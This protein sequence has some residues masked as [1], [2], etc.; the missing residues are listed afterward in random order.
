MSVKRIASRY[1]K[2][3]MDLAIENNKLEEV[4]KDVRGFA[5]AA[6]NRDFYLLIKSPIISKPKKTDVIN[7]VFGK[8]FNQLTLAFLDILVRKGRESYLPEIAAEFFDL[9]RIKQH[10]SAVK[11]TSASPLS[12]A[13]INE[14]ISK[15]QSN[16]TVKT[17][18]EL[19]LK[20]NPE[21]IGGF[22]VET[23]GQVID[24]SVLHKLKQL[25]HNFKDNLYISQIIAR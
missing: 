2:A 10:I 7:A 18:V 23:D 6:K 9:Y 11:I 3:L 4:H 1:A 8:A 17:N 25:K 22:V 14:L 19:E 5:E 12:E 21:L 13:T 24:T 20:T 16:G 15:L